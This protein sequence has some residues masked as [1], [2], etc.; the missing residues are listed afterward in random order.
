MKMGLA[1]HNANALF[2]IPRSA[3]EYQE[4]YIRYTKDTTVTAHNGVSFIDRVDFIVIPSDNQSL[5][6]QGQGRGTFN[7]GATAWLSTAT[8]ALASG[9]EPTHIT[10]AIYDLNSNEYLESIDP[11]PE[12]ITGTSLSDVK[13]EGV[14]RFIS[15]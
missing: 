14:R 15:S 6:F 4:F 9:E 1:I 12:D 5:V 2:T 11:P 7:F 13:I 8:G 10:F 3:N